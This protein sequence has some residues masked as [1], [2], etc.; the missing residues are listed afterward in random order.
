[1]SAPVGLWVRCSANRKVSHMDVSPASGTMN[2]ATKA[3]ANDRLAQIIMTDK[4]N[5]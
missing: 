2:D 5:D 4:E 3:L 1:M